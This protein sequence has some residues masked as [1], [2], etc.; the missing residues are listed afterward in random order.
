MAVFPVLYN[1]S[2]CALRCILLCDPMDYRPP[3]SSVCGILP[4]RILEWIAIFSSR[5]SFPFRDQTCVGCVSCIG[6]RILFH[7]GHLGSPYPCS[8]F[9]LY[10]ESFV[11]FPRGLVIKNLPANAEDM[12]RL[13]EGMAT[14]SSSILA[15]RIPWAEEPGWPQSTGLQ[16]V[17]LC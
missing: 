3:G 2:L 14:H 15:C 16:R 17:E 12:S 6:S 8:L 5:G 9:I 11:D 7:C 13:E 1:I 4:A 10:V